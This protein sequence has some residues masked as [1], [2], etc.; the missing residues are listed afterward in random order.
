MFMAFLHV[1]MGFGIMSR[2]VWG[3][4]FQMRPQEVAKKMQEVRQ[5]VVVSVTSKEKGKRIRHRG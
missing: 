2:S 5:M 1:L 3:F 4:D